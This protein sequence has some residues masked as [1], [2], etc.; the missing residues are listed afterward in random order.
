MSLF[1]LKAPVTEE[2]L[3]KLHSGDQVLISGVIYTARDAAHQRL[4]KLLEQ[5]ESL[6]VDLRNQILYYTGPTP[7]KPEMVTGS[8]GPTTSYRMDPYPPALL[9]YGVKVL[10]GKGPRSQE[11]KEA[12]VRWGGVYLAALG[13]AAALLA[14][15]VRSQEVVAYPDLG[16]EAIRRLEVVDFPAIVI[17]DLYGHDLYLDGVKRYAK[18]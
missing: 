6:P 3:R 18:D 14:R 17:N 9:E 4:C 13:V 8:I 16:P 11:V 15:S 1:P 5:G 12:L 10:I 2:D 7:A